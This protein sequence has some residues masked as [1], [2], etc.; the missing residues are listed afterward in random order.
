[1]YLEAEAK[2]LTAFTMGPLGFWGCERMALGSQ[3]SSNLSK[4]DVVLS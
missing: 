3:C 2:P 4:V 1:M